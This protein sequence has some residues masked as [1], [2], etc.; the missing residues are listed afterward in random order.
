M[1]RRHHH[2]AC[3]LIENDGLI[4]A[5][6]RSAV[7]TLP[8]KWEF[9]GGKIEVG[10]TAEACLHR[11]MREELGAS[12]V[13]DAALS[14]STH[15]Y[16]D[17]TVTLYPFCCRLLTEKIVL[18]EHVAMRWLAQGDF[19][20]LDWAEADLPVIENYLEKTPL[21]A[22]LTFPPTAQGG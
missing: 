4:L 10:E 1:I 18:H 2:V 19:P 9:P 12:V 22:A 3:A 17:F 5:A 13:I 11:E 20:G 14:P 6:Q 7:T 16:P 8:L 15:D 21:L